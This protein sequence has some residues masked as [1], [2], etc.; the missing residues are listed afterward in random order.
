MKL[1]IPQA[2]VAT[3]DARFRVLVAGRRFGKTHLG[4]RELA[5][6][7]R[8][9]NKTVWYIA[10]SYRMAKQIIWTPL[11]QKLMD[12][13]WVE[14]KDESDLRLDLVNGSTIA[15]RGADNPDSLRGNK[16]WFAMLDETADIAE[17]TFYEVIR[18]ALADEQGHALFA[19]TPKGTG[20]WFYDIYT[21]YQ[22]HPDWSQHAF[23]TLEGGNVSEDEVENARSMLDTRTFRQEFEAKFE[24]WAG[25]VMYNW[26]RLYEDPYEGP[27]TDLHIGVDFNINPMSAV[28]YVKTATGLHAIDEIVIPGSNSDELCDE[29]KTRYP[30]SRITA[31]PDPAGVQRKTSAGGRTDIQIL[32]NAGFVCLY[33]RKHPAVRDRINS[34]NSL[35]KNTN[36]ENRLQIDPKCKTLITAFEKLTYKEG[37]SQI[38]K[39]SGY[40]H[41]VDAATYCIEYLFPITDNRPMPAQPESWSVAVR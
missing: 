1:T 36:D 40:D 41:M 7:A 18:P 12:M 4:M 5:R 34:A 38:D 16:L 3:S 13:N 27:T 9:P 29:I 26:S 37:T 22:N 28:V 30:H 24:T 20:N 6:F 25:I 14:K 39:N 17:E 15:L 23:T 10:P 35:L 31:Y 2:Q 33:R 21:R 19:G 32:Q 11:K 8:V